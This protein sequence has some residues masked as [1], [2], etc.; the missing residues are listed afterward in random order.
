MRAG[1]L[2]TKLYMRCREEFL[3]S[4]EL[5]LKGHLTEF[6]DHQLVRTKRGCDG[7]DTLYIPMG[8]ESVKAL[9]AELDQGERSTS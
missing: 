5:T 8:A 4:S 6:S 9:L 1:I 7:Q 3:A 2:F